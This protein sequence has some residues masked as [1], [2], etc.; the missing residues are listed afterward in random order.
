M[1]ETTAITEFSAADLAARIGEFASL[2][3]ACVEDGASIGFVLPFPM[4]EAEAYWRGKVL[5]GLDGGLTLLA[6]EQGGRVVGTVQLDCDTFP[7]QRHRAELRKLLVH[8]DFR[9]RGI[10]R[11]LVA[12]TERRAAAGGRSLITLD[13][14]TGDTAE[15]LYASL[16]Y[17]V[18]G[19]IPGY[20]RD[21]LSDRL[22]PTTVMYKPL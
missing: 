10:A 7:N 15:P 2:L 17:L 16:G 13:T 22:D 18:A 4:A 5:P 12:E 14:R 3:K 1:T 19:I 9:R 8:P 11:K 20:C 6:A 21:T